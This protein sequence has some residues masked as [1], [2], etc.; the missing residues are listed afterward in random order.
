[1]D[2]I[3]NIKVAKDTTLALLLEA[4]DRGYQ[5]EYM[6][7][8][9]LFVSC[10]EAFA[11]A[12]TLTVFDDPSHW[13]ELAE[14]RQIALA[15]LD[16]ILMRKD[17]PFDT[18]YIYA[19]YILEL[20]ETAGTAVVNKPASLR[21]YNEKMSIARFPQCCTPTMVARDM[22]QLRQFAEEHGAENGGGVIIKPLDGMGGASIFRT[23]Q[24]D[25]NFSVI[26]ETLTNHGQRY[27]M[28]QTWLQDIANGD[29]RIILI[30]GKPAPYCLAR[31]PAE[32]ESRGNLAAGGR[33]VV[34]PLSERDYWIANLVGPT[35]AA[36]GLTLVGIDVIGD[37]LTEINVTSPTCV[38]EISTAQG[39]SICAD[40]FDSIESRPPDARPA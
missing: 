4:Q 22:N 14:R 17:P 28:I 31:I 3:A 29:K 36:D 30:D 13:H 33:G 10:G 39:V 40:F 12:Q 15:D 7:M 38:R 1:M 6:E 20:A 25:P 9:D 18:E 26:L 16:V 27:A 19:T 11:Q 32:G 34:Q 24:G 23:S 2:P 8:A 37:Y 5:I 21:H 35:L